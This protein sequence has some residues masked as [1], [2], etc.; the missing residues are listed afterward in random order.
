MNNYLS[1]RYIYRIIDH[2]FDLVELIARIWILIVTLTLI[3]LSF[4]SGTIFNYQLI[5]WFVGSLIFFFIHLVCKRM[6]PHRFHPPRIKSLNI[7][8]AERT[9]SNTLYLFVSSGYL[10]NFCLSTLGLAPNVDTLTFWGWTAKGIN[11]ITVAVF[12]AVLLVYVGTIKPALKRIP[13]T[14]LLRDIFILGSICLYFIYLLIIKNSFET[15]VGTFGKF[16]LGSITLIV[17]RDL[18]IGKW[19]HDLPL[20]NKE[21]K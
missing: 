19:T 17:V 6:N 12:L 8:L 13:P 10:A 3:P 2:P 18:F 5:Y 20:A 15:A 9:R 11:F 7:P 1:D 21:D 4:S 16:L 14:F